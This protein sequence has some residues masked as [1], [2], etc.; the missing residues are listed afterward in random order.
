MSKLK[1]ATKM[2]LVFAIVT[3]L[4]LVILLP[5]INMAFR[6]GYEQQHKAHLQQYHRTVIEQLQNQELEVNQL[7]SDYSGVMVVQEKKVIEYSTILDKI[8]ATTQIRNS[9]TNLVVD[10]NEPF[11]DYSGYRRGFTYIASKVNASTWVI[12][13]SN[14]LLFIQGI[15]SNIPLF[16][17]FIF[18]NVFLLGNI[19]VWIFSR[20]IVSKLQTL[21]QNVESMVETNYRKPINIEG[22]DEISEL[23]HSIDRMRS[24]ISI[25]E[26]TKQEMIQNIGHDLKT[27]IAVIKSYAEAISDGVSDRADAEIIIKQADNLTKRV[28]QLLEFNQALYLDINEEI[29]EIPLKTVIMQA[30]NHFKYLSQCDIITD[31]DDSTYPITQNHLYIVLSNILDNAIRYAHTQIVICLVNKKITIFNDGDHIEEKVMAKIF[32]PYEKGSKGQF[33]LGMGIVKQTLNR[34]DLNVLVANVK[35][36]VE[37]TIEPI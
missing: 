32:K 11:I 30:V 8:G 25:N 19:I 26:L 4:A 2:N 3:T 21:T 12:S 13:V 7:H 28:K 1:I 24:E 36:G 22:A 33:G 37:F 10:Q 14:Q 31:L 27:P 20:N 34:Y 35:D 9:I 6:Y 5:V 18:I 16:I 15:S 17:V 29:T 23:A